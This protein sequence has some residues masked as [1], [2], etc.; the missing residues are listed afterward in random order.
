MTFTLATFP[1]AFVLTRRTGRRSWTSRARSDKLS[2]QRREPT[3]WP[4]PKTFGGVTTGAVASWR[5]R[6]RR[7]AS[8]GLRCRTD[9]PSSRSC[10]LW[11]WSRWGH[12]PG[13]RQELRSPSPRRSARSRDS[14]CVAEDARIAVTARVETIRRPDDESAQIAEIE[15]ARKRAISVGGTI[16]C[17]GRAYTHMGGAL[18][19]GLESELSAAMFAA[20]P[21]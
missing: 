3:A 13:G 14:A 6:E 4:S 7:H 11:P 8:A 10:R 18:Y 2:T 19:E 9:D 12:P 20:S 17:T 1:R 21:A 5:N 16:V 15:Q